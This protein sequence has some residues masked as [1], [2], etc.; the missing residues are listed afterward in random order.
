L[1]DNGRN[2][3]KLVDPFKAFDLKDPQHRK[4]V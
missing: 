3:K 4:Y 1:K 2:C